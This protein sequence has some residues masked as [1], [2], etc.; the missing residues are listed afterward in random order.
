MLSCPRAHLSCRREPHL[1]NLYKA[2]RLVLHPLA[3]PRL[4]A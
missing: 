3:S 4:L 1:M 2:I